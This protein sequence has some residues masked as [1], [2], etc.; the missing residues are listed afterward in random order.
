M[1]IARLGERG[2]TE[3]QR[4]CHMCTEHPTVGQ[5]RAWYA[6]FRSLLSHS[7]MRADKA[8]TFARRL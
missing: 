3:L 2:H 5:W 4:L 6:R 1:G 8:G 7:T